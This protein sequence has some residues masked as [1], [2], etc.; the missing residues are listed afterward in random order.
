MSSRPKLF[1]TRLAR[2]NSSLSSNPALRAE[3]G[4]DEHGIPA[5]PRWSVNELL[6]SYP[7]PTISPVTL[8]HLR[9][10]GTLSPPEGGSPDHAKL[11]E[12]MQN[13]VK[14]VGAVKLA[15]V[16]SVDDAHGVPDGRIWAEGTSIDLGVEPIP[17]DE[18]EVQGRDLLKYAR[19]VSPEGLYFIDSDRSK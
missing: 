3:V 17:V 16:D 12:E 11:M 18:S 7:K 10:L 14:L 2:L 6:S 5:R 9:T 15:D 4:T 13:L 1:R 19:N 8:K